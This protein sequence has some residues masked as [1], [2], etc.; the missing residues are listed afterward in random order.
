MDT[1]QPLSIASQGCPE[2]HG[3][4]T[5]VLER[6]WQ[7]QPGEACLYSQ[8]TDRAASTVEA[9]GLIRFLYFALW[10]EFLCPNLN[11]LFTPQSPQRWDYKCLDK[12]GFLLMFF[13]YFFPTLVCG[14]ELHR[15]KEKGATVG[16]G[17]AR[18]FWL[19]NMRR[20]GSA[21]W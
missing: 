3:L 6:V 12:V 8:E 19:G 10:T 15:H 16:Y 14:W 20:G 4:L 11:S 18:P 13:C 1:F 5:F 17:R 2:S 21:P 9:P 7:V